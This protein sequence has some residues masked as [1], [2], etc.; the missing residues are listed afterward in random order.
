M[1]KEENY[2]DETYKCLLEYDE[3]GVLSYT[4]LD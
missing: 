1:G 4:Y 3:D 2:L